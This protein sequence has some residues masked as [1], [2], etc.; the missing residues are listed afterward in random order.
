MLEQALALHQKGKIDAAASLYLQIIAQNPDHADALYL[1][2]MIEFQRRNN[3]AAIDLMGRA[4]ALNPHNAEYLVNYGIAL[5]RSERF[6]EALIN[7]DR[8][9]AI[10]PDSVEALISRGNVLRNLNRLSDALASF[11]RALALRP[12][13]AELFYNRGLVMRD[14]LRFED[15]LASFD[16]ALSLRPAYTDALHGRAL[17]LQGLMRFDDAL[18]GYDQV[19]VLQPDRVKALADRANLLREQRRFADALAGYDRALAIKPDYPELLVNRGNVLSDLGRLDEALASYERALGIRADYTGALINRGN[20]LRDLKRFDDAAASF[21]RALAI[22]PD[23]PFLAGHRL[24]FKMSIC[25]WQGIEDDIGAIERRIEA[26]QLAAMPFHLLATPL[27]AFEQK[28]CSEI[29]M[30]AQNPQVLQALDRTGHQGRN[31]IRLG[32]FSTDF[33]NH[34]VADHIAGLIAQHDRTKFEVIA[35]SFGPNTR[36]STRARLEKSFDRFIEAGAFSDRDVALL[37]RKFEIDIAIDL[38]GFTQ[39]SR[40]RVFAMRTAPIQVNYFGYPGTTGS[41]HIDYIIADP[42]VIP[43]DQRRY[44]REKIAYLPDTY[45]INDSQRLISSGPIDRAASGLPEGA[46]V[47]CCFNNNFKIAPEI[48]DVWMR[49]LKAVGGSVLWLLQDNAAAAKNLRAHAH[50]R[51]VD[52][53][54]I[55]FAPR[56]GLA[57]YLGRHRLADLFLDTLPYNAHATASAAL[58]TGLPVLTCLGKT[59][60]G[61]VGASLLNAIGLPD[62]VAK[63]LGEYEAMAVDLAANPQKLLALRQTLAVNR[64]THPL[65]DT[66]RCTRAIEQ[67]YLSMWERHQAGLAPDHIHVRPEV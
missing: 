52:P 37:A 18:T 25:D 32:Y 4:L 15:A 21:D 38:N 51:G 55:M 31:R 60:P 17:V 50:A 56:A 29:Y 43:E 49:V 67:A 3:A 46:F 13:F 66:A 22:Q 36:D 30:R 39:G 48:F 41:E 65:F 14:M 45:Q 63:D 42:V 7:F 6:H 10:R 58:W 28:S 9:L 44:Y 53:K 61:R 59:F 20:V 24:Y 57:E 62:L 40:P 33:R 47:F 16:R 23:Y 12:D 35:F 11:D 27:S 34:V 64:T 5:R 8:A 1:L 2:G 19:L 26:Q 54:R